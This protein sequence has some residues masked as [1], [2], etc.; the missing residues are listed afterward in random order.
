M[1]SNIKFYIKKDNIFYINLY[2]GYLYFILNQHDK[3][4][5]NRMNSKLYNSYY[6]KL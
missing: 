3:Y 6:H 5:V 1:K 2:Y 4:L